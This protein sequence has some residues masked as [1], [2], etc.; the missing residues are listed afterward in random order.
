VSGGNALRVELGRR[1]RA[2]RGSRGITGQKL[3]KMA[4]ISPAHLSEIERGLSEVSSEKL[5]RIA[6]SL[7]VGVQELMEGTVED[8]ESK[9]EVSF[10]KAL[11]DAAE[12][13]GWSYR[14]MA[15]LYNAR[16]SLAARRSS[17]KQVDWSVQDWQSFYTT[18]KEYIEE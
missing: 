5:L 11:A 6:D 18:V 1:I 16:V 17:G 13:L 14:V 9:K 10:P 12:Q 3:A 4:A 8:S 2:L 7:G 15:K